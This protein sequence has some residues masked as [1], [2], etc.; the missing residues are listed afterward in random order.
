MVLVNRSNLFN[1]WQ[2]AVHFTTKSCLLS[3][4]NDEQTFGSQLYLCAQLEGDARNYY[5]NCDS[6]FF[7]QECCSYEFPFKGKQKS[8]LTIGLYTY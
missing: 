1:H 4:K 8:L 3:P 5:V 7:C 6:I 2:V